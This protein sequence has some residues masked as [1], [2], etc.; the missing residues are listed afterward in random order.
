MARVREEGW[1]G[2]FVAEAIKHRSVFR[3]KRS[4]FQVFSF[5]EEEVPG[6]QEIQSH[7]SQVRTDVLGSNPFPPLTPTKGCGLAP[8]PRAVFGNLLVNTLRLR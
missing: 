8:I 2:S 7:K 4:K 5:Q 6:H 1:Q 3:E